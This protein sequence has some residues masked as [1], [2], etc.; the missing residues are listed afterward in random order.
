MIG[1]VDVHS[2]R[3]DKNYNIDVAFQQP[4]RAKLQALPAADASHAPAPA[5]AKPKEAAGEKHA[6][7]IA[8]PTSDTIARQMKAEGKP[9]KP[10]APVATE[11]PKAEATAENM[12]AAE[13]P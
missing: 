7:E 13:A 6:E 2:F 9:E 11:T 4:D 12:P 5:A 3:E 8:P 1:D 10:A